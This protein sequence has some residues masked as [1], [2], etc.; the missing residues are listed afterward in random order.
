MRSCRTWIPPHAPIEDVTESGTDPAA[1]AAV[2]RIV[3]GV[4]RFYSLICDLD[5]AVPSLVLQTAEVVYAFLRCCIGT[6]AERENIAKS[7]AMAMRRPDFRVRNGRR[8]VGVMRG[9]RVARC[10]RTEVNA[11]VSC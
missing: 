10:N 7:A 9:G 4:G 8:S 5:T 11:A 1:P 2:D 3:V 6:M